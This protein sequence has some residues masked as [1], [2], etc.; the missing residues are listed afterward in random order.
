MINLILQNEFIVDKISTELNS[1]NYLDFKNKNHFEF[2]YPKNV[3]KSGVYLFFSFNKDEKDKTCLYI[4]KAS[5]NNSIGNR[6]D[7]YLKNSTTISLNNIIYHNKG[8]QLI[9]Y[10][11]VIP[12]DKTLSFLA[13][14]LEEFLI[15]NWK[16]TNCDLLNTV[17]NS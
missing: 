2:S 5:M 7:S 11:T 16:E 15:K 8:N 3:D 14:A 1:D 10:L 17:G 12:F 4:G 13:P 6:L 9:E